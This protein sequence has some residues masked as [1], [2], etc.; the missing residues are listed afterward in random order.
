MKLPSASVKTDSCIE[1]QF[2][3]QQKT[4]DMRSTREMAEIV[5]GIFCVYCHGK[6]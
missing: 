2:L 6:A 3:E 5:E 4:P 1:A